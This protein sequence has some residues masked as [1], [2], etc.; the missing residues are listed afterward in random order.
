MYNVDCLCNKFT[1]YEMCKKVCASKTTKSWSASDGSV[2]L[3][4]QQQEKRR[5]TDLLNVTCYGCGKKGHLNHRCPEPSEQEPQGMKSMQYTPSTS[6]ADTSQGKGAS[7]KK[8]LSGTLYT[9][10]AH[11]GM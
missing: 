3:F 10:M 6:K 8:P 11:T 9:V 2:T 5:E 7:T 4:S 1:K